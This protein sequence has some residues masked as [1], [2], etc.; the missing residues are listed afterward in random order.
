[1]EV[2]KQTLTGYQKNIFIQNLLGSVP[3]PFA[4]D[5]VTRVIE[6]YRLGTIPGTYMSGAVTFPFID[7]NQKIRAIQVKQFDRSNHTT[8]TSFLHAIIEKRYT[9]NNRP[10]PKWLQAYQQNPTKVSCLFGEHLLHRYP[11]NP[12]ALVEAPKTALYGTLYFGFPH[13]PT[14]LLWLA[15]YNLSS[16]TLDKC[17]ALKGRDVYLFP[18]LSKDGKAFTLW[19]HR[20]KQIQKHLQ[21]ACFSVSDLLERL[22][23]E[24]DKAQGKDLADYLIQ[25]DWRLFRKQNIKEVTKP[26]TEPIETSIGEKRHLQ[27]IKTVLPVK[28]LHNVEVFNPEPFAPFEKKASEDWTKAINELE[29]YF[30]NIQLPTQPVKLSKYSTIT[31]CSLFIESHFATIKANNGKRTFLPYLNRLQELKQVLTIRDLCTRRGTHSN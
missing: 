9:W 14:N 20:A 12:I 23:C 25:Q 21:G 8:Q 1:M 10:L 13:Q 18:D 7:L 24:H 29:T 6:C 4:V 22:A 26:K 28:P 31:N 16:L 2:L 17:K 30:A 27:K 11:H 3:Y 15:V 19:S 5:V